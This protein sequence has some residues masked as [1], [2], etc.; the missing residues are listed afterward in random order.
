MGAGASKGEIPSS[1]KF[2]SCLEDSTRER[3]EAALDKIEN[4]FTKKDD[5]AI[6][7]RQFMDYVFESRLWRSDIALLLLWFI[8][9]LNANL[10]ADKYTSESRVFVQNYLVI[11]LLD[12]MLI[13]QMIAEGFFVSEIPDP[14]EMGYKLDIKTGEI[15]LIITKIDGDQLEYKII[16]LILYDFVRKLYPELAS[17]M[18]RDSYYFG[19]DVPFVA[20]G[21][22][23]SSLVPF[24]NF[25]AAEYEGRI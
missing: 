8:G 4:L 22:G 13:T 1:L 14:S 11:K 7:W 24:R 19:M 16:Q 25:Q 9:P 23:E 20:A 21:E 12:H 5:G 2:I 18:L 6:D 15:S 17:V 3:I 10:T